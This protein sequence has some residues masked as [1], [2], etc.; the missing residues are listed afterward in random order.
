M[1]KNF[2][3]DVL[4]FPD[5]RLNQKSIDV[6]IGNENIDEIKNK[7]KDVVKR[8]N[9][10]GLSAPQIGEFKNIICI[11]IDGNLNFYINP[12]IINYTKKTVKIYEGC[13]SFPGVEGK[14]DRPDKCRAI[15]IDENNNEIEVEMDGMLSRI[16]QHEIDHL[17]GKLFVSRMVIDER[18]KN[19]INLDNL[20]KIHSFIKKQLKI[21]KME[22]DNEQNI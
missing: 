20:K 14:I 19:K 3:K 15:F 2:D 4:L 11:N 18:K 10:L 13:L 5:E 21:E 22:E 12:K 17:N 16:F 7:M 1:F 6:D 8:N 9:A